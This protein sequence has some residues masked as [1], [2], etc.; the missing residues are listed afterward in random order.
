MI[1]DGLMVYAERIVYDAR[2][3]FSFTYNDIPVRFK[4]RKCFEAQEDFYKKVFF[5]DLK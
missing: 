3:I 4:I 1:Y 5:L 2:L